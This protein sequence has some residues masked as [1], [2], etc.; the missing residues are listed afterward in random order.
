[1]A[2]ALTGPELHDYYGTMLQDLKDRDPRLRTP[3]EFSPWASCCFNMGKQVCTYRHRDHLNCPFGWCSIT[4]L[5]HFD[6]RKGG[7]LVLWDLGLV[8][9]FP[10]GSTIFIPS[11]LVR[12]S[13]L[14]VQPGETRY[15]FVQ[16]STGALFRWAELGFQP[17][18]VF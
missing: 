4:A 16:W 11:A 15:S 3:F 8:V 5:G 18:S 17:A 7:H 10:P 2:F 13:N 9:Q 6:P 12:H 1:G 14:P